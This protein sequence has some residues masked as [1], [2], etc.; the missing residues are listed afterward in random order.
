[1]GQVAARTG[2]L[3]AFPRWRIR[4]RTSTFVFYPYLSSEALERAQARLLWGCTLVS[5]VVVAAIQVAS[6]L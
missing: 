3:I 6:G 4:S 2:I 5:L 1:L